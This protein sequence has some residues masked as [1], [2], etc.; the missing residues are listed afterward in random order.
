MQ[1]L[2]VISPHLDDAVL[3]AGQFLAS[4]PGIVVMTMF[5]GRP[6]VEQHTSFDDSCGFVSST[7]AMVNR[8]HEDDR[9]L[10]SLGARPLRAPFLDQQYR[11]VPPSVDAVTSVIYRAAKALQVDRIVG[12]VGLAHPDHQLVALA[13]NAVNATGKWECLVYEEIP[14]R[15][16]SPELVPSALAALGVSIEDRDAMAFLGTSPMEQKAAAINAYRSQTRVLN[17]RHLGI[18]ERFWRLPR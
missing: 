3:S 9:A 12:P 1:A 11:E 2:L 17:Q 8:W 15:I 18:P 7:D 14:A 4:Y 5:A 10:T 13:M 6:A 16:E